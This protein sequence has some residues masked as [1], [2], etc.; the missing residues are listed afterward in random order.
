M[1]RVAMIFV[2][3]TALGICGA[4]Q[5]QGTARQSGENAAQ[6]WLVLVDKAD[7]GASW[8]QAAS[9][10]KSNVTKGKWQ[11]TIGGARRPLGNVLSRKLMSATYT[12]ELPGAPDGQYVVIQY[13]TS[14]E[15]KKSAVET[16]TPMLEKDGQWRV[17]GYF[18]R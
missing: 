2:V 8:E 15:N 13:E 14:F 11:E 17:S 12:A 4:A 9:M 3:I 18:I 7:Y 6:G 1:Q 10:F 5:D 16:I